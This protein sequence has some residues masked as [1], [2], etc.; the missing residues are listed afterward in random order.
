MSDLPASQSADLGPT[1]N[2]E[3][4][5][6]KPVRAAVGGL[7]WLGGMTRP[8]IANAVR[9]VARQAHDLAERHWRAVRKITAYLIMESL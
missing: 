6:D 1:R 8:D 3:L 9:A 4:L 7:V 5:C 2:D